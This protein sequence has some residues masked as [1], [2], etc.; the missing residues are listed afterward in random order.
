METPQDKEKP[1]TNRPATIGILGTGLCGARTPKSVIEEAMIWNASGKLA[2]I[3][4]RI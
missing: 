3:V 4:E 1:Q 2:I